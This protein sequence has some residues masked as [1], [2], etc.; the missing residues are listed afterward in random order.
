MHGKTIVLERTVNGKIHR[1]TITKNCFM[2][3]DIINDLYSRA[4]KRNVPIDIDDLFNM[5]VL[6]Y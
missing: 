3:C 4:L 6:S 1:T 2:H 5:V